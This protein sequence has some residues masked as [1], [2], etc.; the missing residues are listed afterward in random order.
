MMV[1]AEQQRERLRWALMGGKRTARLMLLE[2]LVS[3]QF[4]LVLSE[5][6]ELPIVIIRSREVPFAGRGFYDVAA[7]QPQHLLGEP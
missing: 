7:L 1:T 6:S 4:Q 3:R 2:L 5:Q